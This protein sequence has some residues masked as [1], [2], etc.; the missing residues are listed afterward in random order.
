MKQIFNSLILIIFF[1][2]Y[3]N[4]NELFGQNQK[5]NTIGFVESYQLVCTN[6][7]ISDLINHKYTDSTIT[8]FIK[9]N[10]SYSKGQNF[11]EFYIYQEQSKTEKI[12]Q[13]LTVRINRFNKSI[14]VYDSIK[15]NSIPINEWIIQHK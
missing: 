12:I 7:Y 13:I 5:S 8:N 6:E 3:P 1:F 11:Y 9:F 15:H 10:S 14:Y 2:G 4:C